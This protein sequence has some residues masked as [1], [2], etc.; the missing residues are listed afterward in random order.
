MSKRDC[1]NWVCYQ[2]QLPRPKQIW[3]E[4]RHI[5][6]NEI[7]EIIFFQ[8]PSEDKFRIVSTCQYFYKQKQVHLLVP[9]FFCTFRM[10]YSGKPTFVGTQVTHIVTN[11]PFDARFTTRVLIHETII[12][13]DY[14]VENLKHIQLSNN[15]DCYE[16]PASSNLCTEVEIDGYINRKRCNVTVSLE[17]DT[18][19]KWGRRHIIQ[20][21]PFRPIHCSHVTLN[22]FTV[23][24]CT[25]QLILK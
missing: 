10:T 14:I 24:A 13:L 17:D 21:L 7:L 8:V 15:F 4:K 25:K 22:E 3:I 23:I 20:Y 1:E 19:I 5:L 16:L 12:S 11:I 9:N 2:K 18:E 6:P